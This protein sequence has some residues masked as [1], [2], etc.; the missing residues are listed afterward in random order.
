[1]L[2][3]GSLAYGA[4]QVIDGQNEAQYHLAETLLQHD[5]LMQV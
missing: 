4:P 2:Y 1:M 5:T 3:G